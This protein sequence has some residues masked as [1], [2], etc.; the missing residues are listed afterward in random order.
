MKRFIVGAAALL[1]IAG[2][3]LLSLAPDTLS[4][5]I[6]LVMCLFVILG[7]S[8]GLMPALLYGSGFRTARQNMEQALDVQST[9]TWIAVFKFETLFRQKTLDNLFKDYKNVVEQQKED[10]EI[11]SDIEEYINEDVLSLRT[12]QGLLNQIPGTLTGL[13]ILGTFIGLITGISSIGF[14][15]VEAA[16][17]SIAVLLGGI[18]AAFYTSI[19]GV[20]LSIIF[21]ILNRMIW[22]SMLREYGLFV[23]TFHKIVIPSVEEQTRKKQNR[24]IKS[25]LSRLDRLPKNPG[26]SLSVGGSSMIGTAGAAANEQI[27]MPQITEGLKKGEFTF[28]LQPRVDLVTR[29]FVAAEALVRWNHEALGVLTPS[30]FVPIL[31]KN[32]YITRMDAYIWETVCKTIRRWIDAG[33][34]PVPVSLNLSKTDILA[35]DVAGFFEQMLEKYR[36]PPRALELEIAKNAY[37]QSP[38]TTAEVAGDLRRLGFKVIMDG[39]DG[40][41]ISVNMLENVETDALKLDLRFMSGQEENDLQAIFDQ[42]RKLNIEMMAEGIENTEQITILRK[43][44]CAV[45]QGYYFYKPMSIEEFEKTSG[46]E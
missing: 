37:T 44:G 19:S 33:V 27:L 16:L 25:I 3:L 35:M 1:M 46:G 31:E 17:E 14:S 12:W 38:G 22:N 36:I 34:R 13:G 15:S 40:D 23:E 8:I 42:A 6:L 20:I 28:Y 26:F 24:D 10:D 4:M 11:V 21:N 30:S 29:K 9:E 7:F 43:A 5:L 18:E 45:G 32:G 41:Y 2:G 39:F